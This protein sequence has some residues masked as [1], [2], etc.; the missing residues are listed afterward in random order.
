[1]WRS[2]RRRLASLSVS[3]GRTGAPCC[4]SKTTASAARARLKVAACV[5][6]PILALEPYLDRYYWNSVVGG[7]GAFV[8]TAESYETFADAVLKK[9][10]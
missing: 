4:E 5:G 2:I 7:P 10:G 6:L 1:M 8:I 3:S 9:A